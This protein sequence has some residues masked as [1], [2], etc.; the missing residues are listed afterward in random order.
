MKLLV[1]D[2]QGSV[3]EIITRIAQQGGWDAIHTVSADRLDEIIRAEGVDV[4]LIDFIID[5]TPQSQRTGLTVV[6]ALRERGHKLPIILFTGWHDLVDR[7]AAKAL[8]VL[9]VLEKPLSIQEL[10][11]A[12]AEAK[13]QVQNE[14]PS[15]AQS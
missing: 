8:G 15:A 13:K 14:S 9:S 4:L 11:Q 7:K 6:N 5:G 12:L 10:R 1:V 3:G 2:D